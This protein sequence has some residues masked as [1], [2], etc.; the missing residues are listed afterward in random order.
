MSFRSSSGSFTSNKHNSS[1]L[2]ICVFVCV[3]V[4]VCLFD[5]WTALIH[6]Q[7]HSRDSK[8]LTFEDGHMFGRNLQTFILSVRSSCNI[9]LSMCWYCYCINSKNTHIMDHT[10]LNNCIDVLNPPSTSPPPKKVTN[11]HFKLTCKSQLKH[12][13]RR[14]VISQSVRPHCFVIKKRINRNK[15]RLIN[16]QNFFLQGTVVLKVNSKMVQFSCFLRSL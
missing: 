14:F 5:I 6:L 3:C 10:K 12:R 9:H 4:C 11:R 8:Y 1:V 13:E 7:F 16:F 2:Y 15:S